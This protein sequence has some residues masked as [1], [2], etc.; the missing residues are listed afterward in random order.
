MEPE[1]A[2]PTIRRSASSTRTPAATTR[3]RRCSR[4]PSRSSRTTRSAYESARRLLQPPGRVRQDH[5]GLRASAPTMEPNNPEAWHTM[6]AYYSGEGDEGLPSCRPRRAKEYVEQGPRGRGQGARD[7]P[8]LLRGPDLTRTSCCAMQGQLREGPGQAERADQRGGRAAKAKG[9]RSAEE[10][11]GARR[12][13]AAAPKKG[14][15]AAA[16][17]ESGRQGRGRGFPGRARLRSRQVD[18]KAVRP[19]G[20]PRRRRR[21]AAA[22]RR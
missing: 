2:R 6:A 20:P 14:G 16:A 5:G 21:F 13:A 7:Q 19:F 12:P 9:L 17:A 11:D 8:G 15:R 4:R 18:V 10:A 3:P 1:R 22:C